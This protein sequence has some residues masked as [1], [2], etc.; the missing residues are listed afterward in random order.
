MTDQSFV[1]AE[2]DSSKLEVF[3]RKRR[4]SGPAIGRRVGS[5]LSLTQR[6]TQPAQG[7]I[8]WCDG[9]V[10]ALPGVEETRTSALRTVIAVRAFGF[11]LLE[12]GDVGGRRLSRG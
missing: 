3:E 7:L 1:T 2:T 6:L 9:Q 10:T 12:D 4:C 11:G 5:K 8:N